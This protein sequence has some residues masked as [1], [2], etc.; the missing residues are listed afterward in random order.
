VA[1]ICEH[2]NEHRVPEG[3][4]FSVLLI[5]FFFIEG[6]SPSGC[7][8]LYDVQFSF[9]I[10]DTICSNYVSS[11]KVTT[12]DFNISVFGKRKRTLP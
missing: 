12:Y 7:L 10:S 2:G 11:L 4:E 5:S 9:R 1:G 8:A 3:T 6:L